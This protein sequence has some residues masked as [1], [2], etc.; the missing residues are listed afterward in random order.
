MAAIIDYS[1]FARGFRR[2]ALLA[3]GMYVVRFDERLYAG[4]RQALKA[5][6]QLEPALL[7]FG[8][9]LYRTDWRALRQTDGQ[10]RLAELRLRQAYADSLR[11]EGIGWYTVAELLEDGQ[12]FPAGAARHWL[13]ALPAN[14]RRLP[15]I[16]RNTLLLISAGLLIAA[17]LGRLRSARELSRELREH[18]NSLMIVA[19]DFARLKQS[20][21]AAARDSA[22][23]T[24]QTLAVLLA[25]FAEH[26]ATV[27]AF[28][29]QAGLFQAEGRGGRPISLARA[30]ES[31]GWQ[32]S[33]SLRGSSPNGQ[34]F[35]LSA[36]RDSHD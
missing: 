24:E 13:V 28:S 17:M 32:V 3:D 33:L 25:R 15:V 30:L 22:P 35:S 29:V 6:R 2:C 9:S 18:Y 10:Y 16:L 12:R 19:A 20:A 21:T 23:D 5:A 4:R 27:A 7:P 8:S 14:S 31:D 34:D 1:R 11:A 26:G 36:R